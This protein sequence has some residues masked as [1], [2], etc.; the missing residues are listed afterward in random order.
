[1]SFGFGGGGF[2]QNNQTSNTFGGGGFG[3]NTNNTTSGTFIHL[4]F[5]Q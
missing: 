4:I 5:S 1:M 3:T 2:G